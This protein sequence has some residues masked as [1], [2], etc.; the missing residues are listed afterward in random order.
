MHHNKFKFSTLIE[1][2]KNY[3]CKNYCIFFSN[4]KDAFTIFRSGLEIL[5]PSRCERIAKCQLRVLKLKNSNS[6]KNR[7]YINVLM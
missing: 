2:K 4:M 5:L 7:L 6:Y 1:K 3:D